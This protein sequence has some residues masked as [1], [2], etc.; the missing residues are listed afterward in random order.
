MILR[1][2]GTTW[3]QVSSPNPGAENRLYGVKAIN[4]NPNDVWAVG[5][6]LDN[7]ALATLNLHWDGSQWTHIPGLP[8]S[9]GTQYFLQSVDGT[10][11]NDVWAVGYTHTNSTNR[12]T[13]LIM[14]WDGTQWSIVN[15]P[16]P[17]M[18]NYLFAVDARAA[19]DVWAVG[20][21]QETEFDPNQ[22]MA[23][24]WDGTQWSIVP[25][26]NPGDANRLV[27]VVALAANDAWAVGWTN[28]DNSSIMLIEHYLGLCQTATPTSTP[29]PT[30]TATPTCV[31]RWNEVP[32]SGQPYPNYNYLYDVDAVSGSDIWA[33][34]QYGPSFREA[35]LG[36]STQT[37]VLHWNGAE[38]SIVP[39][40]NVGTGSA[41]FGVAAVSSDDVWAVGYSYDGTTATESTLT[42][43]W[44][45]TQ[46]NV[47]A[48]PNTQANFNQM[49]SVSALSANDVWAVG[50][51]RDQSGNA[52]PLTLH[53]NGVEWSIVAVPAVQGAGYLQDVE[54]ISSNNVWAVGAYAGNPSQ[55]LVLHWN[56][57][58]W[59]AVPSPSPGTGG[60]VL[61]GI[62]ASSSSEVWAVGYQSK[63]SAATSAL[64]I[65]WDGTVWTE[66]P[67]PLVGV[68]PA[69]YDVGVVS[70]ND[71][72]A[73]GDYY[74]PDVGQRE[75]LV[76]HWDGTSW[77]VVPSFNQKFSRDQ[78]LRAI[79]IVGAKDLWAVGD[80][81]NS[82]Q[83]KSTLV[84]RY[85]GCGTTTT[86]PTASATS[87]ITA[88]PTQT[89]PGP[90]TTSTP[91]PCTLQF[92]DV[93][94]GSTFYPFVR[95]L[96]C[97]N[98]LGGYSDGTFRPNNDITRGQLSKIVANSAGFSEPVSGRSFEDVLPGSSFYQFVERM[99]SRGII[100]GYPC[101]G[102]AEPCGTGNL[103]YFR[104]NNNAT[105][106]QISKI[107][108]ESAG[109][110]DPQTGQRFEDVP[111]G[112][113][114]HLWIERL[115][116]EGIM[117]GYP[118]GGPGEPCG[119]SNLPYFR[120]N[121]KATRGQTSKIVANT[122]FPG[123]ETP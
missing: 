35:A 118:C 45:G 90:T 103:P 82:V 29:T 20:S 61:N 1:W 76:E 15:S 41:L 60:N 70:T 2:N 105:R 38:W 97:R 88:Q 48:S 18:D 26:G 52:F 53:W 79:E 91:Q 123:C 44:N 30:G 17:G 93:P 4:G 66:I 43:H 39:S 50:Y 24:H 54:A 98:I 78:V 104:P 3:N 113:T 10:A 22:T 80:Y 112:S 107:V 85:A 37:L 42:L 71:V 110:S 63:S 87:T 49:T 32:S 51:Y 94:S 64:A 102:M 11:T 40:P 19:N 116:A 34:G 57:T 25:T 117:G 56:G 86:T 16:N 114:F 58:Q 36:D 115:A 14:R 96:S 95:C 47:V 62:D 69:F 109:L 6:Y 33:V 21:H 121:A 120:P 111:P 119:P 46:W 9:E 77:H 106:G 67:V 84:E 13:T 5:Y 100:G 74:N 27:G 81:A 31:P 7:T 83:R 72:W 75:T 108:S 99:A 73:V 12:Y 68:G 8:A 59:D 55:T 92:T 89:P 28:V 23:M 101:G 122:F 65:R